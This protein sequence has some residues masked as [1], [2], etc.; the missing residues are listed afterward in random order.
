MSNKQIIKGSIPGRRWTFVFIGIV[1]RPV[2]V[3]FLF[4]HRVPA[5]IP[6]K[7]WQKGLLFGALIGARW[8]AANFE[9]SIRFGYS[10]KA[11]MIITAYEAVPFLLTGLILGF[12]AGTRND[13][14]IVERRALRLLSIPIV[15]LTFMVGRYFGYVSSTSIR[16]TLSGSSTPSSGPPERAFGSASSTG[17]S[18]RAISASIHSNAHSGTGSTC[19]GCSGCS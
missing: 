8:V 7:K 9:A 14:A 5:P 10:V 16:N 11:E 3:P 1:L 17:R 2:S 6:G 13:K 15:A 19:S 12:I 4:L 18:S